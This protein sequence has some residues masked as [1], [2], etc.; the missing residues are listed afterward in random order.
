MIPDG[1]DSIAWMQQLA[2]R[3]DRL[4]TPA[5]IEE[6]LDAVEYLLEA[7]DPE[8]QAPAYQLL[9]ALQTRLEQ[10]SG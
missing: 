1:I 10:A 2:G 5:E 6:A 7:L 4:Q 3:L 9:E 8:L